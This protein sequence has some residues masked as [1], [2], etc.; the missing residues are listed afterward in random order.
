MKVQTTYKIRS[1]FWAALAVAAA[2]FIALLAAAPGVEANSGAGGK[3]LNTIGI[4]YKDAGGTTSYSATA[5]TTVTVN[6]VKAG[7]TYSGRPTTG[8]KGATA[9]Y[10][11]GQ[12]INSGASASYLLALTATA[13][14]GDTYNLSRTVGSTTNMASNTV[15]Y[16]TVKNDGTTVVASGSPATVAIGASVIQEVASGHIHIPGGS[17]ATAKLTGAQTSDGRVLVIGNVDY[18]ISS[19]SAGTAPSNTHTGDTY[20]NDTGTPTAEV[21]DTINLI[22]NPSGANTTFTGSGVSVGDVAAEQV[23]VLVTVTGT[24]GSTPGVNGLVPFTL[25]TSDSGSGHSTTT[26]PAITTTFNGGWLQVKKKVKNVTK[27][28]SYGATATGDPGDI[29]EYQVLVN[30]NGAANS[31]LVSAT[32]HVPVYTELVCDMGT[33]ACTGTPTTAIIATINNGTNTSN[34]TYQ[35]SDDECAG[36]PANVGGGNAAGWTVG[37]ALNFY[38]GTGCNAITPVGGTV[39]ASATYTILYRVKMN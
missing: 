4:T 16:A 11:S 14:G 5:T 35:S 30:N 33:T 19:V 15:T 21:L 32:D 36:S 3:I 10:P 28:G 39:A 23:L 24:I 29:L 6:L 18:L 38:M 26:D 8:S 25:T 37:S 7:I 20:Y 31:T 13:N 22:A 34:V 17:L 2:L 12:T 27:S 1:P 9:V